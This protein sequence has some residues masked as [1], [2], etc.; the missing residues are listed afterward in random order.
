MRL[1]NFDKRNKQKDNCCFV[2]DNRF[3]GLKGEKGG[4]GAFFLAAALFYK[5]YSIAHNTPTS[6]LPDN[7][8]QT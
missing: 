3:C 1:L 6:A 2:V 5:A 8:L 7:V 4:R